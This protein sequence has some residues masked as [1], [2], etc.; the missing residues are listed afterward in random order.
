MHWLLDVTGAL[1][2]LRIQLQPRQQIMFRIWIQ[3][4][5]EI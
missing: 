1:V 3:I 4:Q 2:A 5:I